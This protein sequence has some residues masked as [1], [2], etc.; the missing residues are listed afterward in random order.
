M[1][2][3]GSVP[4]FDFKEN[5]WSV[6]QSQLDQFFIANNIEDEKQKKAIFLN[7]LSEKAYVLLKNIMNPLSL[8]GVAVTYSQCIVA[9][10]SHF[11]PVASEFPERFKFYQSTKKS[12]ESIND[13]AARVRSLAVGCSFGNHLEMA[14]RDKFIMGLEAGPAKDKIFLEK[15]NTLTLEKAISI[16]NATDYIRQQYEVKLKAEDNS[17]QLYYGKSESKVK[18][19]SEDSKK[20]RKEDGDNAKQSSAQR[21]QQRRRQNQEYQCRVCGSADHSASVCKFKNYKCYT[22]QRR[23]HIKRMCKVGRINFMTESEEELPLFNISCNKQGPICFD[24]LLNNIR[25][26]MQLDTG[27][28][29]SVISLATFRKYFKTAELKKTNI[30]FKAYNGTRIEPK[31]VCDMLVKFNGSCKL[32][33][34]VVIEN[35]GPPL[36]RRN[37]V[38]QF[39]ISIQNVN[40]LSKQNNIADY[41]FK[42]FHSLFDG[43]L[44]CFK[45][46]QVELALEKGTTPKFFKPRPVPLAIRDKVDKEITKHVKLD[47]LEPVEY[48]EWGTPIVPVLKKTGDVRICGDFK[49][50]LN[51]H[52]K[53]EK[54]PLPRIEDLFSKLYGGEE[55]TKLDLSMAYQQIELKPSSRPLTTI[56]TCKGLYQ[57]KRLIYGL[58][59]AP[60]LFQRIMDTLLSG[61]EGVVVFLDDILITAP[62]RKVHVQ[63]LEKVLTILQESGF[64]LAKEK[65]SFLNSSLC[66]LGHII[67]QKGLHTNPEKVKAI[68]GMGNPSNVKETQAFLG[69]VNFYRKFI[70]NMSTIASPLYELLKNNKKF[71]WTPE[72]SNAI[73]NLKEALKSDRCLGHFSSNC[74]TR[75]TVDASP[76]G[77][78]AVLSQIDPSGNER[79]IEYASRKLSNTERRYSQLDKEA[80]AILFGVKKFHHY[81][82]GRSFD[83]VTDNK[84]LHYILGPKKGIPQTAANRLQRIAL[85]LSAYDFTINHVKS[86]AN[87]A[88]FFSRFPSEDVCENFMLQEMQKGVYMNYVSERNIPLLDFGVIQRET[89]SDPVLKKVKEYINTQWPN[90]C[91]EVELKPYF[92]RRFEL[93][94]ENGCL[95]W[96][97]RI[98]VPNSLQNG[99]VKYLHSSHMG[100]SKTKSIARECCWWPCQTVDIENE[101]KACPS[102]LMTRPN[103]PKQ[104][105]IPWHWPQTLWDRIHI[106][107]FGPMMSR[108]CLVV[109]DSHSK[110]VE[111]IDMGTNTTSSNTIAKLREIF[112]RFGL[113]RMVVSDNGTAFVPKEFQDFLANNGITHVTTPVGYPATNGQAENM[114]KSIKNALKRILFRKSCIQ[115]SEALTRYIFDYRN[116]KHITTG[117]S[118][119]ELMFGRQLRNRFDLINPKKN[120][121]NIELKLI[122]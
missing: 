27:S 22:C 39:G 84:P 14:I 115:F 29:Y 63:R 120:T 95:Y 4:R 57:Y 67:D 21:Q 91:S 74:R 48:C 5:I 45:K 64:K 60:A 85:T 106:D 16:A 53:V 107:F 87:V 114:V 104:K 97:Y 23:G 7:A 78:G 101:I 8:D 61:L 66:Y 86:E 58:A 117:L 51:P 80:A 43:T 96:G 19:R 113:P 102:C 65:C 15:E 6:F 93:S 38:N 110:W 31:G 35:G 37:F 13:W 92:L 70:P 17:E 56:S 69:V 121:C 54:Y 83:L 55:F 52:L 50:T 12:T 109:V 76:I 99:M 18:R 88:D 33:S 112:A 32:L 79:P 36:L 119:A 9:M 118:P 11:K 26:N 24:V 40:F 82:Y 98:I 90:K 20:Q 122:R 30:I 81:L 25:L 111:C 103:P 1:S 44:G 72:C 105:L 116:T 77:L 42:K 28:E 73:S 41:V 100:I 68:E 108:W 3:F 62:C 10:S 59:S 49:V 94:E 71:V 75:L 2:I 34:V 89:M 47:V 46:Q